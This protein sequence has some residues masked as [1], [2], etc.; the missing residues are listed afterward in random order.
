MRLVDAFIALGVSENGSS[1]DK[2]P[3]G[4]RFSV[5]V[6]TGKGAHPASRTIGTRSLY[7]G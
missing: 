5:P 4:P 2:I 3:E 1:G 7:R 6:K